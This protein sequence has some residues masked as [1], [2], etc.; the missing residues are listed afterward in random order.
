MFLFLSAQPCWQQARLYLQPEA[1]AGWRGRLGPA[2]RCLQLH[3]LSGEA[4][5]VTAVAAGQRCWEQGNGC[6]WKC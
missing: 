5:A 6:L 3:S 2:E 4:A 1:P